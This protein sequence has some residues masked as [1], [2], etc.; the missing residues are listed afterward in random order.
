MGSQRH[1]FLSVACNA[2]RGRPSLGARTQG[3]FDRLA[4]EV[5][6]GELRVLKR[7]CKECLSGL[8]FAKHRCAYASFKIV[9]R[10]LSRLLSTVSVRVSNNCWA[11]AKASRHT[12]STTSQ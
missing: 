8:I 3:P 2:H 7:F 11:Q 9:P 5:Q 12:N 1:K 10:T 4:C 6:L